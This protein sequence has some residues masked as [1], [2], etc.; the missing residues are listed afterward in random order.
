MVLSMVKVSHPV[1]FLTLLLKS[2]IDI[3]KRSFMKPDWCRINNGTS[4]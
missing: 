2:Q 4:L 3:L 1:I